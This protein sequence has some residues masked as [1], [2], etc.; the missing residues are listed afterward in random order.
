MLITLNYEETQ[1]PP[2]ETQGALV[3]LGVTSKTTD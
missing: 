1:G 2:E 3:L